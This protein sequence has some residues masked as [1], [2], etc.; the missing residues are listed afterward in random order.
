VQPNHTLL[1]A[2]IS[3]SP[4]TA[5]FGATYASGATRGILPSN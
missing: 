5:A 2:Q 3:T 4:I 1:S